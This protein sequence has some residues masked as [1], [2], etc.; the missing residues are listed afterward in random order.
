MA[1]KRHQ[2]DKVIDIESLKKAA[3]IYSKYCSKCDQVRETIGPD[4]CDHCAHGQEL[5]TL[6]QK[7]KL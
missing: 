2:K 7:Y 4:R 5:M 6:C 3:E 1:K